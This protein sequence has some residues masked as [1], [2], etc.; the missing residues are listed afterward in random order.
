MLSRA[1]PALLADKDLATTFMNM[2]INMQAH[3][4]LINRP[5]KPLTCHKHATTS[6]NMRIN[7]QAHK[8]AGNAIV[9]NDEK[10]SVSPGWQEDLLILGC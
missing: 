9:T 1:S 5:A 10:L 2:R 8:Q 3:C 4:K 7:M 6:I